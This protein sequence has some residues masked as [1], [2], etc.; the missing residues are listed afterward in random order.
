MADGSLIFDT[1]INRKGFQQDANKLSGSLKAMQTQ[2]KKIGA[3]AAAAFSVKQIISFTNE[4]KKAWQVQL[5]AETKLE[6]VMKN[7]MGA[8]VEQIQVTKEWA[9]ELQKVGVI[10][11]EITLSGL[12]ELGTYVEN[13]DSLKTMSVV[14][15]DMLAQQ[16]GLNATAENAVTISTMLGKV[17]EG[18]TSALSRYGYKF[19]EA[20]EQLLKYGTE[21]QRVATLAEVV[22]A[23]VG[24]MNEAL[25]RTPAGRLKQIS[26]NMGDVKEQFGKA[27]TNIQAAFLPVLERLANSLARVANLAVKASE[28]LAAVF[29]VSL[30]SSAAVTGNISASV[31]AEEDL[32]DAVNDTAKAEQKLAGF[33]KI[34]TLSSSSGEK[35]ESSSGVSLPAVIDETPAEKKLDKLSEQLQK[36]IEPIQLA[37]DANSPEL[38]ANAQRAVGTIKGLFVD[39]G[40]SIN[41]V[42][43]NGSGARFVGN[44]ITLF[45]DVLGIIGDIGTALKN[46]WEDGGRGTALIQSFADRWN[47]L[48][49]VIHA[50]ADSARDAWNDGTG[51]QAL[52][53]VLDIV[54]RINEIWTNLRE[55]FTKAW[56]ENERGTTII[57]GLLKIGQ[58]IL[59]TVKRIVDATVNWAKSID[60]SPA[61]ESISELLE[62]IKPLTDN[63]GEGLSWF[64]ENVLLPLGKW[65]LQKAVPV[66]IDLITAAVKAVNSVLTVLKPLAKAFIENFLKPIANWT[67]GAILSILKKLSSLLTSLSEWIIQHKELVEGILIIVGS[68]AAAIGILLGAQAI[69]GLI[70][71]LPALLGMIATQTAALIANAAA[72]IAA[73]APILAV[74]AAIAAVIAIGILLVKH[75]DDIKEFVVGVWKEIKSNLSEVADWF[76]ELFTR[77]WE[78]IKKAWSAVVDFFKSIWDGIKNAFAAVGTFFKDM[79]QAAWNGITN[80]FSALGNWFSNRWNDV[81]AAFSAVGTWFSNVFTQAWTN[82]KEAFANVSSFFGDVWKAITNCFSHVTDWFKDKFSAAWQA[83]KDVFSKGGAIFEGIADKIADIFKG[84]VNSLI[85]GINWVIAQPFNAINGALDGLR[86]IEILGLTPFDWLPSIATPEIPHL[87]QGTVIPANYGNFLAMLGDNKREAEIVSPV[88]AIEKAVSNV[89]AKMQGAQVIHVHLNLDGREIGRV[90]V[91]A[92]NADNARKGR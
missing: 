88:S 74:V 33:D 85:D 27:V 44:L 28:S 24:G 21:E 84:V 56:T 57:S 3:A 58:S 9:A 22:E 34:N 2:L 43:T 30:D 40:D 45:S 66:F 60:F 32:T 26:N 64:Y 90:A 61:L 82:I 4:A 14:L 55:Q 46:A 19:D 53:T 51:E 8:T 16:Y 92:V 50:V 17:L 15:D 72:W 67:G 62:A 41:D 5:E 77:A 78:G 79:F 37:W 47:A 83:V 52:G 35:T 86:D 48:L 23:S 68:L 80:I 6:Q 10:G 63:I 36:V 25:A 1:K 42:W 49:E 91:N 70:A 38:I 89:M 39:I 75:W 29:G 12:Q 87:A 11:D 13:A 20:Q 18:Q 59:D 69:A 71:A 31:L 76:K 7:T 81:K 65:T 73:A 54:T